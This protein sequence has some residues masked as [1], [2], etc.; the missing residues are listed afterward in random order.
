MRLSGEEREAADQILRAAKLIAYRPGDEIL[1]RGST[2][3]NL[4]HL[5]CGTA[6]CV[7][8]NGQVCILSQSFPG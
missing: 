4:F 6:A 5:V 1:Q 2:A 7:A 8:A 3:R